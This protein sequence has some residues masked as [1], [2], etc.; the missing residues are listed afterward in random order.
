MRVKKASLNVVVNFITFILGA[1]PAFFVRKALLDSLG[2]DYLGLSSLY[3]S[4][5]GVLSIV[6][7][8]IGS[9]II[10][11]LYKPFAEG[12]KPRM[13]GYLQFYRR[14]YHIVGLIIFGLGLA[15][16]PFLR[17]FIQDEIQLLDAAM[18][19]IL[20][21][22]NTLI[23]YFFSYKLCMLTVAQ[24]GYKISI[25][26]TA[27]KLIIAI[28]HY[29]LL[30]IY[31][32][33]YLYLLIQIVINAVYFIFMNRYINKKYAWVQQLQDG[34]LEENEKKSLLKNIKA[35]FFHKIGGVLVLGTDNLIISTT[36]NLTVVGIYNSFMLVIGSIQGLISHAFSGITASVGNLLATGNEEDA[37]KV[38]QKLFFL[39]FWLASFATI[40]LYNTLSQFVSIWLGADQKLD[41]L[42][43]NIILI[44]FY[45][46]LMRASVERFKE[47]GGIYYQ[48]R[49]APVYEAL[50]NLAASIL[51]VNWIGL[52]GVFIG[53]LIS[54]LAV[55]FWVKPKMVY[56]YIFKKKL[57][58][59]FLMYFK[60]LAIGLIPFFLTHIITNDIKEE[61]SI[62]AL[63]ANGAINIIL[64]NGL[65]LLIFWRNKEF[66]YFKE[67]AL[68]ILRKVMYLSLRKKKTMS[69]N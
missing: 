5:I 28:L 12:D 59:Y 53:T 67:M 52:A 66:T 14:F 6:E 64:I 44:N 34:V 37:Y 7:L 1:L 62:Y 16:I 23:S 2:N 46:F 50:I 54:N 32:D 39:N 45:F 35:L 60:Y 11:S 20:F 48:D 27:S 21:L 58:A 51:L 8:G 10:Y 26:M 61:T 63:V 4:I 31:P 9:A 19:F 29:L 22:I 49:Y 42:S 24:D 41:A 65:Y 30:T 69:G 57:R 40:F 13:L 47:S 3:T 68:T 38:H 55:I 33:F 17:F 43:L 18:Y 56:T 36:I 15:T 25:A